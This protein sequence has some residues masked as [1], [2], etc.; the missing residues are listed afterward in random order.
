MGGVCCS[1]SGCTVAGAVLGAVVLGAVVVVVAEVP[2][3]AYADECTASCAVDGAGFDY[4]LPC[5]SESVV[6]DV[7]PS[8]L[9]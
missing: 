1:A 8:G 4:W 7:V 3:F 9:A 2:G 5:G 6:F